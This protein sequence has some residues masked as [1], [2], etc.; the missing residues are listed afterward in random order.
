MMQKQY[1]L[2]K[3]RLTTGLMMNIRTH[4]ELYLFCI[5]GLALIIIFN[6]IP[7]YSG[8]MMSFMNYIPR[9]GLTGSEWIGLANFRTFFSSY[10][11]TQY[12]WNTLRLSIYSLVTGFPLPIILAIMINE[13]MNARF[14]KIFQTIS[15][16]PYFISTVVI[17][18]MLKQFFSETGIVNGLI[19]LLGREAIYFEAKGESFP[20]MYVWSGIWQN[21]GYS[22]VLYIATLSSVDPQLIEA[23]RI[24]GANKIQRIWHIDIP[25][26]IPTATI[27]LI[28]AVG[29]LLSVGFEKVLLMQTSINLDY[30]EVIATYVY[31]VGILQSQMS[32]SAAVGLSNSLANFILLVSV[33][34]IIRRMSET[35]LW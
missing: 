27:M 6:Y 2:R 20:H 23:A 31:K 35:S 1:T 13:V 22:S 33:N 15:Y 34:F 10:Y 32:F 4:W 8:I 14:K 5:P 7:M 12:L 29:S 3:L 9:R 24:D 19:G 30:S 28:F 18:S 21:V 16:A 26:I 11:F 25:T 17:V